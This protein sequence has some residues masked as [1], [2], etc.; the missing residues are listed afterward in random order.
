MKLGNYEAGVIEQEMLRFWK[1]SR[2]YAKL[3]KKNKSSK[4]FYFLDGPPYT[5]GVIHIGTA[6]N[7]SLKDAFLRYK[8]MMGLNVWDRA[9]YDMHGIP[10]EHATEKKLGIAGKQDIVRLGIDKF[11]EACRHLALT[12]LEKMNE[13]FRRLGVWMDFDDPYKTISD[14]FIESEW[15]LIKKA[16]EKERLYEGLR[17]MPWCAACT[18]A[19]AK[20]E[21]EYKVVKEDSIFIK[22]RLAGKSNEYLIIWTTTPWTIPF[23]LAVMANPEVE[24]VKARVG[25]EYW[26]LAKALAAAFVQGVANKS[27]EI[28]EELKGE[29]MLGWAYEHPFEAEI[30]AYNEL[31]QKHPNVHTVILS[32]EYVDTSAGSGLVHCAPGC[33]PEDYEVGHEYGLPP[34]NTLDEHGVFPEEMG[35]FSGLKAKKDDKQFVQA[36]EKTGALIAV[37]EVEHDYAHCQRCHKPVI[38]RATKQW[39]FKIEDLKEKMIKSNNGIKWTP[40]SAYNAFDSWLRNLRDNSITKQ[41][42]WG[43]PLPVWRCGKCG[44]Y[45][46][47]GSIKEL[48]EKAGK[49]PKDLHKPWIDSITIPCS[50]GR[51]M[52]RIPDVIDVWVDAGTTSWSCLNYPQEKKLFNELFPAEFILEGKDQIRGWFN[53]LMVASMIAFEKPSFKNVYMHGFV[54]DSL[55]RKMS[56]SLG[57]YILPGEVIGKY[58]ADSFRYFFIGN[59]TPGEDI[60][61]N[62]EDIK[63]RHKNLAVLWNLH[64]YLIDMCQT[65]NFNP[66]EADII[67]QNVFS[68]EEKYILSKLNSAI[69]KCSELFESYLIESVPNI[70]EELYLELSRTYIQLVREKATVGEGLE[71]QAVCLVI[72]KVLLESLKLLAPICPFITE[73]VYQNMKEVFK[74]EKESIH[75]FEWPQCDE[76]QIDAELETDMGIVQ[77]LVQAALS[78]R[79][80]IQLNVRWPLKSIYIVSKKDCAV[81]ACKTLAEVLQNQLNAKEIAV[82]PV[83]KEIRF[84]IKAD[85]DKLRDYK[86]IAPQIIAKLATEFPQTILDR[87]E[88][89]GKYTMSI[90]G[91]AVE[92]KKDQLIIKREVPPNLAGEEFRYG[93]V[94]LDKTR[95]DELEAEGFSRELTRRVQAQRKKAGLEKKQKITLFI[96]ADEE[97]A[98]MIKVWKQQIQ[99]K[100][101][102]EQMNISANVP[103]KLHKWSSDEKIRGHKFTVF[104]DL[105]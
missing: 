78:V 104:F 26:Y 6:W 103:A 48:E 97:L 63:T 66:A 84:V 9:G 55:G 40:H 2:I 100:V 87:L 93:F 44:K 65:I 21:L 50:C 5:S 77:N 18:T 76:K 89:E 83:L 57:N 86:P 37:T 43:C 70:V 52:E 67:I 64:K 69:K 62:E 81:K 17:T 53:L 79:E 3:K 22:F 14:G 23:N 101:G 41:R 71:K 20:H 94:Y 4:Q 91:K 105:V 59:S 61:Y 7:K 80:K 28:A 60:S 36:L 27:F 51:H 47:I 85:F 82:V 99:E 16:H 54:Q 13:D 35:K 12:N 95:T 19:S 96:T 11:T 88:R 39:F 34:Y 25:D 32:S 74:L 73:A 33:G 102:A 49:L 8:R 38:F 46:V 75:L 56:K 72:Y 29:Q 31:K 10:T 98:E 15:W 45:E 30:V 24:Y 42:F 90:N 58:G 92:L 68:H 1:K